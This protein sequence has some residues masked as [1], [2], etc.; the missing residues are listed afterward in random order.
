MAGE[1]ILLV[2]DNP[3]N[4]KLLRVLLSSQGYDLRTACDAT[5]ALAVLQ[6]FRARV[7]L[8]DVQ[9]PGMDGLELARRLKSDAQ[10][11]DIVII[12]V[13]AYAMKGDQEKVRQAGCDDYLAKP[14]DKELLRRVVARHARGAATTLTG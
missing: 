2:D 8:L 5:E 9:L 10:T 1:S 13:T 4:L 3:D 7:I 6:T 14:I 12:A 11:S